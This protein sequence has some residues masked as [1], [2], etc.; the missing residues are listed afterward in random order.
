MVQKVTQVKK[1]IRMAVFETETEIETV[2][3]EDDN[4]AVESSE[5]GTQA[6]VRTCCNNPKCNKKDTWY[7]QPQ[8]PGMKI[9]AGNFLLSI[10]ILLAKG[11]LLKVQQPR[12]SRCFHTWAGTVQGGGA[13]R[14]FACNLIRCGV[15]KKEH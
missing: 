12:F 7:S 10:S 9:P 4:P 2:T 5:N 6:I 3:D 14:A 11:S 1:Q 13:M 15:F 8:I